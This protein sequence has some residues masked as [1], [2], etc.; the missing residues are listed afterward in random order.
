MIQGYPVWNPAATRHIYE[1]ACHRATA[2]R[3]EKQMI[4]PYLIKMM[5]F[6]RAR[7][8]TWNSEN[9]VPFDKLTSTL[10]FPPITPI[11]QKEGCSDE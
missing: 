4:S 2:T 9:P 10:Y 5:V 11:K 6:L 3:R 1:K 8:A 7:D